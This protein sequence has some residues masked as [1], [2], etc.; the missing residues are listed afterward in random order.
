MFP[1]WRRIYF[2]PLTDYPTEIVLDCGSSFHVLTKSTLTTPLADPQGNQNAQSVYPQTLLAQSQPSSAAQQPVIPTVLSDPNGQMQPMPNPIHFPQQQQQ[3]QMSQNG[4]VIP[5]L[6]DFDLGRD[7]DRQRY[8]SSITSDSD[9]DDS[10][11]DSY[12]P[13]ESSPST[14]T[15]ERR[16]RRRRRRERERDRD[17]D[18]DRDRGRYRSHRS[19]RTSTRPHLSS[20]TAHS[21]R[22][23][24]IGN[25]LPPPPKDILATTPYRALLPE[26]PS[27]RGEYWRSFPATIDP[28][29][30]A[31]P[32]HDQGTLGTYA[33]ARERELER[34][35]REREREQRNNGRGGGFFSAL[36]RRRRR[37][38]DAQETLAQAATMM[39]QQFVPL[40]GVPQ[41]ARM[42]MGMPIPEHHPAPPDDGLDP[43]MSSNQMPPG[44]F[45][46]P[47]EG[48]DYRQHSDM[49]H[50]DGPMR[51]PSPRPG[52]SADGPPVIPPVGMSMMNSLGMDGPPPGFVPQPQGSQMPMS[53]GPRMFRPNATPGPSNARMPSPAINPGGGSS[54]RGTPY[55]HIS[56]LM[57]MPSPGAPNGV[58]MPSPSVMPMQMPTPGPGGQQ[59]IRF[60][61]DPNSP[62]YGF[63]QHSNHTILYEEDLYPTGLHLYEAMKF[64]RGRFDIAE[65]IR[66]AETPQ[67]VFRISFENSDAQREDWREIA[68]RKVRSILGPRAFFPLCSPLFF[69]RWYD[70]G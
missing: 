51:M 68:L 17:R 23:R 28:Y 3:P 7:R 42:G 43:S 54:Q 35:E 63:L 49:D 15:Y 18:R 9:S 70:G 16:R 1:W 45:V 36:R 61:G 5:D 13:T 41:P 65:M 66:T 21:S 33:E 52:G 26:L 30:H 38:N 64:L 39:A 58:P 10:Y 34:Q 22:H 50:G 32:L 56:T 53:P 59:Q 6:G 14:T 62:Y 25:P 24:H 60:T 2:K 27:N 31:H 69:P 12:S 55:Q 20:Q 40:G 11:T 29:S 46:A 48:M 57:G 8:R 37:D 19:H 47:P 4:P 44:G 67:D